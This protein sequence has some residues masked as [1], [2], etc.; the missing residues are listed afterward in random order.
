MC[1]LQTLEEKEIELHDARDI[2]HYTCCNVN[3]NR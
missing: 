2:C 3:N 1:T